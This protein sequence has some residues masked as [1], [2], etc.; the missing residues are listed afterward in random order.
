MPG[1]LA[2][3]RIFDLSR[4]L[5]GPS[6]TQ[7]LGDLGAEVIKIERPGQG[8]DTRLWG[9]PFLKD[10][11]GRDTAESAYYVSCNRSKRSLT[12]DIAKPEGQALARRLIAECDVVIE[13]FKAGDLAR[14]GLDYESLKAEFP[15]LVYCSITGFGQTG[16]YA[17]RA[18]Y[19][20]LIQAM[21]GIMSITG[22][23]SGPPMKVGVAIVDVMCGMYACVAILAALRHRDRTGAGQFIDLALLDTQVSWLVNQG[24]N[25]L[26]SGKAPGR[27][28]N[29]HPN[30]VPYTVMPAADGWFVLGVGNDAQYRKFCEFAGRPELAE[31]AR[32]S[33]NA[34]RVKHR[35]VLYPM[36]EEVTRA[37]PVAAWIE[38]LERLGVPAGPVNDIAQVFAD[39]QVEARGMK[40]EM[41]RE[42]VAGGAVPMIGNPIKFSGTPIEYRDPPPRLG[43]HTD[44]VL[45]DLL[46]LAPEEIEALRRRGVV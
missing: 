22:E 9:P 11:Q 29:A 25:Y 19:D 10:G 42:G 4:I 31:D 39:P 40:I 8:D 15:K 2:G 33:T 43:E 45:G 12:L 1:P 27:L 30:I 23:P 37:K 35:D 7:L 36:L 41:E 17:S 5:A 44:A 16:P 6:A 3:I 46:G 34:L 13:N 38:G 14:Y 21:G 20:I 26:V 18:G 32:F 28:G 24:A